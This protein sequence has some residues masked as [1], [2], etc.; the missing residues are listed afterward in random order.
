MKAA[1]AAAGSPPGNKRLCR[2]LGVGQPSVWLVGKFCG[3][4]LTRRVQ[5]IW[6]NPCGLGSHV[7]HVSAE[8]LAS[9]AV[10]E[11]SGTP[12]SHLF[13]ASRLD[14]RPLMAD[15]QVIVRHQDRG[16]LRLDHLHDQA[17]C[18]PGGRGD[19]SITHIMPRM[20]H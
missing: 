12:R 1:I 10:G 15:M 4:A 19:L 3:N 18:E 8:T 6:S 11:V 2:R 13:E 17:L 20:V 16:A 14:S 9:A 7:R 5:G